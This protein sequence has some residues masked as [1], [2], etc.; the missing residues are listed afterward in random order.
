[1]DMRDR[2]W[3]GETRGEREG[4]GFEFILCLLYFLFVAITARISANRHGVGEKRDHRKL[5]AEAKAA[6]HAAVGIRPQP[7]GRPPAEKRWD[8]HAGEW[9]SVNAETPAPTTPRPA[10]RAPKGETWE[11]VCG[12]MMAVA[13]HGK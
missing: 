5:E 1:M 8:E 10:G 7:P 2:W 4:D 13:R 11:P 3:E 9:M 6:A 12:W